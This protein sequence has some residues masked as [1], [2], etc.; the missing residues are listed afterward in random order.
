MNCCCAG[1]C[2]LLFDGCCSVSVVLVFV[3]C[4]LFLF[5]WFL[6]FDDCVPGCCLSVCAVR[7]A[8][9]IVCSVLVC[10]SLVVVGSSLSLFV[11][12][13]SMCVVRLLVNGA[14]VCC[15]SLVACRRRYSLCVAHCCLLLDVNR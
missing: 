9:C 10:C 3:V 1:R 15:V 11:A 14:V 13:C 2:W 6:L 8:L 4:L 5:V 7:C 12:R